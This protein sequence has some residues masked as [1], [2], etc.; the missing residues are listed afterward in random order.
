M[1]ILEGFF[2]QDIIDGIMQFFTNQT[3]F[4]IRNTSVARAVTSPE[5]VKDIQKEFVMEVID[6]LCS[7]QKTLTFVSTPDELQL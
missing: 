7:M 5:A 2:L 3:N 1:E 4:D 6:D